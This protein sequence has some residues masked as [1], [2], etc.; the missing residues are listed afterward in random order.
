M[1]A[2][3]GFVIVPFAP[4]HARAFHDLNAAWVERF[5]VLEGKDREQ[6]EDPQGRIIAKG[7]HILIAEDE[8]GI[9]VGCVSLVPY[10]PGVLEL[11]KMAVADGCKGLGIGGRLMAA[12]VATARALGAHALYLES[13]SSLAPALRL[14]ERTGF[15]HLSP[16]ERPASPYERA[17]VFMRLEL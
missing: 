11:A 17:N 10:A 6:L 9:A 8:R 12:S 4:R 5:F 13:N 15:R 16:E 14:Y 3:T 7:G 1:I 2:P